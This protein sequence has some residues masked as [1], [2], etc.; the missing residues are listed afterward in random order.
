[1]TEQPS[2]VVVDG[3]A[4]STGMHPEQALARAV[5]ISLFSWRLAEPDDP[6]DADRFGWWADSHPP[7][8]GDRIGSRL[9]L[10]SRVALTDET[11]RRARAYCVEALQWLLDDGVATAVDVN[12][13][14][15]GV[16]RL[17]ISCVITRAEG[18][19]VNLRFDD[20]WRY[21]NAV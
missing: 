3:V 15:V 20:V 17:S 9:W 21:I 11:V 4:L 13:A 19:V 7:A 14:R 8:D 18:A 12:A 6:Y 1:M 5:V 10:L 2:V 16:D